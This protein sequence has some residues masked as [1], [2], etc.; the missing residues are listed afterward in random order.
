MRHVFAYLLSLSLF[1]LLGSGD[2]L[3]SVQD[4]MFPKV[5]ERMLAVRHKLDSLMGV[6]STTHFGEDGCPS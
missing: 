2:V 4:G 6:V 5:H 3:L 1:W